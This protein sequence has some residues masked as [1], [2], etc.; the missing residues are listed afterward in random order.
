MKNLNSRYKIGSVFTALIMLLFSWQL[1]GSNIVEK[2]IYAYGEI[3]QNPELVEKVMPK[4]PKLARK[5]GIQGT[6]EIQAI[7]D[8]KGDV[9]E[10]TILKSMHT[11][12]KRS[13]VN[14]TDDNLTEDEIKKICTQVDYACIDAAKATKFKPGK[15]EAKKVKVK[16]TIPYTFKLK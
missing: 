1:I 5:N 4:Y 7:V 3:D 6:V 2:E 11:D 14:S 9:I 15:H 13:E 8:E 12:L 16:I 10:A